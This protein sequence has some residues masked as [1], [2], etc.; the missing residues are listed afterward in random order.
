[1]LRAGAQPLNVSRHGRWSD[2]SRSFAGYIEEAG[3]FGDD[4]PTRHLL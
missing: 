3:G 1:M 2:G 4:N